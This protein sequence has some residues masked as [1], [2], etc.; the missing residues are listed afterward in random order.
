MKSEELQE[1]TGSEP[2]TIEEEYEMQESW[3][4]DE[5]S[6]EIIEIIAEI[7]EQMNLTN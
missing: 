4:N 5:K 1:L 7:D 3:M 6:M 2:L